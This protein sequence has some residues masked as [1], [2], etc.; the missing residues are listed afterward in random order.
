MESGATIEWNASHEPNN[1]IGALSE[2]LRH[3]VALVDDKV[4]IEDL[5]D[6]SALKI[7]HFA[8]GFDDHSK[9]RE[10]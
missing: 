7:R 5:E 1:A 3:G 8:R 10:L 9:P 2:L 6:L 4:L